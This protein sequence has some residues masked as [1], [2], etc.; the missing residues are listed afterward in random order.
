VFRVGTFPGPR[1][2][3]HRPPLRPSTDPALDTSGSVLRAVRGSPVALAVGIAISSALA[4]GMD[5]AAHLGALAGASLA[6]AAGAVTLAHRPRA[7]PAVALVLVLVPL[8]TIPALGLPASLLLVAGALAYALLYARLLAPRTP[9]AILALGGAAA[10][11][12]LAGWQ[13][14]ASILSPTPLLLAATAFLWVPGHVWSVSLA[15][16]RD[17][18]AREEASLVALA[19]PRAAAAAVFATSAATV[20]AS[21]LLVPALGWAYGILAV[22]AGAILLA[23]ALELRRRADGPAATR[24]VEL[25]AV[26]LGVLLAGVALSAL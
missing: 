8:A 25:S 7:A 11:S 16:E 1:L 9:F 14:A 23:G 20:C 18:G 6:A 26:Y 13:S 17:R 4:A 21:L 3:G 15:G 2:R 19:G 5:D 24:T 22:P 12:A 10:T